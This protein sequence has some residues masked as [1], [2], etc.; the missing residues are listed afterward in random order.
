MVRQSIVGWGEAKGNLSF[1][2]PH[3]CI[4]KK[5]I[6]IPAEIDFFLWEEN[7]LHNTKAGAH[8]M[9][10]VTLAETQPLRRQFQGYEYGGNVTWLGAQ[11]TECL[12]N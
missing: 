9:G 11:A 1:Q 2:Y 5:P 10:L 8:I 4:L 7:Q 3:R 12:E 6:S